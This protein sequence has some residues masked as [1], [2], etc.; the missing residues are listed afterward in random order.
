MEET[1][2]D[3]ENQCWIVDGKVDACNHPAAMNCKCYGKIHAGETTTAKQN[4]AL[5]DAILD[6][7]KRQGVATSIWKARLVSMFIEQH[8][9]DYVDAD[10]KW[11]LVDDFLAGQNYQNE[12]LSDEIDQA[13]YG[14]LYADY[15]VSDV[16]TML[17]SAS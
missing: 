1:Y 5:K 10:D 9:D 16:D 11:V 13:V 15:G 7:L 2:Y 14:C 6:R 12:D 3:Y 17:R 8:G 4:T